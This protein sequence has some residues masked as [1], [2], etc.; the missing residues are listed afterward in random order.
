MDAIP[1]A[2][3]HG[4]WSGNRKERAK[5]EKEGRYEIQALRQY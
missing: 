2:G 5:G 3:G 1:N 4:C